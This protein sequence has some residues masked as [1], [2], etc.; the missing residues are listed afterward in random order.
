[1]RRL[2]G[3]MTSQSAVGVDVTSRPDPP[4]LS[5]GNKSTLARGEV[6]RLSPSTSR[7][8]G[9][10]EASL[11]LLLRRTSARPPD[12]CFIPTVVFPGNWN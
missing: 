5:R 11:L 1:M 8:I 7:R 6:L 4:P 10:I 3:E 2:T 12:V 9:K